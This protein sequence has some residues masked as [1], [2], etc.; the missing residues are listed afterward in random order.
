MSKSKDMNYGGLVACGGGGVVVG[1]GGE[2]NIAEKG[3]EKSF[4]KLFQAAPA[5]PPGGKICQNQC[6]G[7]MV[8]LV[9]FIFSLITLP[10]Y[11]MEN[12]NSW[13]TKYTSKGGGGIDMRFK[14]DIHSFSL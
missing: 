4:R 9:M 2:G 13:R 12:Q 11:K 7:E 5:P 10:T 14:M 3:N 6:F 8:G 1:E